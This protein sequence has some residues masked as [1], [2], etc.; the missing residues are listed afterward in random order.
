MRLPNGYGSVYKLSGKRRKPWTARI[1][2]GMNFDLER[3]KAWQKFRYLGFYATK[4]E[5]LSAL[6]NYN[7]APYDVDRRKMTVCDVWNE[8]N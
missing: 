5:A 8:W 7:D 6:A 2:V 4:S 3:R 1:T